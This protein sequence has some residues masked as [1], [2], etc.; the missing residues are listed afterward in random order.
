LNDIL[1]KI[2]RTTFF[3]WEKLGFHITPNH[4][5]EPIPDTRTLDN[6]LWFKTS[7]LVGININ[8]CYQ[9]NL[10]SHFS[11]KYRIEY[12]QFPKNSV[13]IPYHYYVDNGAFVSVDGELLYCMIRHFKP[14]KIL[15]IGSG[16]STFL[17]AQAIYAN[18]QEL[19]NYQCQ[20][21]TIDP[22][23]NNIIKGG[24]PGFTK[25]IEKKVQ[26]IPLSEF[27]KLEENDILFIDSSH[28]L[29]IGS[30]VHYLILDVLPRLKPG[31]IV[32]FHDIFLPKEYP[33]DWIFKER[34]FW[35]E[36]YLL[37]AFLMFNNHFEVLWA[38]SYMNFKHPK[39]IEKAFNSYV[40]GETQ[41]GSFWIRTMK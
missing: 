13:S 30:D 17:S 36:Q 19:N 34:R 35:T 8:E 40:I 10:L 9:L 24:F 33:K 37:Q 39:N 31:V 23:P 21:I 7:E 12:D 22:Y 4:Y 25:N 16:Y 20:L 3:W 2:I 29:K 26:D 11:S 27:I 15:E 32:H 41:P 28:V 5:Y 6:T 18:N 1:R 14:R 38:G